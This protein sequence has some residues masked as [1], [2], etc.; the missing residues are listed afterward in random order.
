[1]QTWSCFF[2]ELTS[3]GMTRDSCTITLRLKTEVVVDNRCIYT[4]HS[5]QRLPGFYALFA[6]RKI[7][8]IAARALISR[9]TIT[10][11]FTVP[12]CVC[13]VVFIRTYWARYAGII[14]RH[15][16]CLCSNSAV[17]RTASVVSP[18][19]C[20]SLEL[21]I[22]SGCAEIRYTQ[23]KAKESVGEDVRNV[24]SSLARQPQR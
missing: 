7:E 8:R 11:E 15:F 2:L 12:H 1:M 21:S 23:R 3:W 17:C 16:R 5:S 10:K 9:C 20:C 13:V 4:G 24:R 14:S 22:A 6:T 18:S 19:N